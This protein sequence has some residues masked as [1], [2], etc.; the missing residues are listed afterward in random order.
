MELNLSQ[1]HH[2]AT[3]A[4]KQTNAKYGQICGATGDRP[5]VGKCIRYQ[6]DGDESY[7]QHK[8]IEREVQKMEDMWKDAKFMPLMAMIMFA[9]SPVLFWYLTSV[10]FDTRL[11]STAYV[12]LSVGPLAIATYG[13]R[14]LVSYVKIKKERPADEGTRITVLC[15][16]GD[17]HEALGINLPKRQVDPWPNLLLCFGNA[18]FPLLLK[19]SFHDEQGIVFKRDR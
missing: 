11:F 4:H 12:I 6:W 14:L 5:I 3:C 9:A 10:A 1:V 18:V 2:C 16:S 19:V 7:N 13:G 17:L 15:H 8:V